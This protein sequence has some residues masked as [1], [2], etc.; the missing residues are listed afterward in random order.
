[1]TN[2]TQYYMTPGLYTV[3]LYANSDKN[4]DTTV[5]L[6]DTIKVY[7]LPNA[8]FAFSPEN[9]TIVQRNLEFTNLSQGNPTQF[10]WEM[11]EGSTYLSQH[12]SHVYPADTGTYVV[13]LWIATDKGCSDSTYK[14]VRINSDF[15]VYIPN[16]FSPNNDGTNDAFMVHGRGIVDA[17]MWVFNRWGEEVAYLK[18][19]EPMKKG[20]D[21]QYIQDPAKQDIYVYR[22]IV[23]DFYGEYHEFRG[24]VN[25]L[26]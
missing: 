17:E 24:N 23:R 6:V 20:W 19:L 8:E 5:T 25:L 16:S 4:C 12:V 2:P 9:P 11:G 1:M 3:S 26:R 15:T 21:G 18:N 22:I 13:Y 10:Y 7:T 14:T